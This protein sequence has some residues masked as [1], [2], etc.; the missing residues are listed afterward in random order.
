MILG[1]LWL[2]RRVF[3]GDFDVAVFPGCEHLAESAEAKVLSQFVELV[4]S[5]V[6]SLCHGVVVET[7]VPSPR[8]RYNIK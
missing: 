8:P 1:C 7:I 6:D 2:V 5:A 4:V 3:D